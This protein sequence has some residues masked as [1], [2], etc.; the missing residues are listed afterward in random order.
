LQYVFDKEEALDMIALC[1]S[2][3]F[4]E[5]YNSDS[6]IIPKGYEKIYTSGVLGMENKYQV[7]KKGKIAVICFRGSIRENSVGL[8]I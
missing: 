1:N 2:F 7:Y 5:L 6:M 3:S 8:R 4:I